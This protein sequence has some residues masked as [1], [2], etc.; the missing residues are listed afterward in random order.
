LD[1]LEEDLAFCP[2]LGVGWGKHL[3]QAS[4]FI[5]ESGGQGAQASSILH[6]KGH[7]F[8]RRALVDNVPPEAG[9]EFLPNERRNSG[10]LVA[11]SIQRLPTARACPVH[12]DPICLYPEL[13]EDIGLFGFSSGD[14]FHKVPD[15]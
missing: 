9:L 8:L 13:K 1:V 14:V 7:Q 12:V 6:H 5:Q 15:T 11:V 4:D 10:I 2:H 3:V